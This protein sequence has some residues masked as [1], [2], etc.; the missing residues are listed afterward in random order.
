MCTYMY[1]HMYYTC[2]CAKICHSGPS[3]ALALLGIDLRRPKAACTWRPM[4]TRRQR[5]GFQRLDGA[6]KN[7]PGQHVNQFRAQNC[8]GNYFISPSSLA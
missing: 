3:E 6:K 1:I 8:S 2:R 5:C 7:L 4:V